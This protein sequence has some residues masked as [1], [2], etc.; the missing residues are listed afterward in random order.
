[1]IKTQLM[2]SANM[3]YSQILEN[4]EEKCRKTF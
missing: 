4:L 3:E 1:M 2:N